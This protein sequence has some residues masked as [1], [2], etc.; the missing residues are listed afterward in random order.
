MTTRKVIEA[1][2]HQGVDESIVYT[3]DFTPWTVTPI[4]PRLSIWERVSGSWVERT[5]VLA[6]TSAAV[7]AGAMVTL[8]PIAGVDEGHNYLP[9][10]TCTAGA[11][12]LSCEFQI[13]GEK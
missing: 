3:V 8:P 10:V 2:Q 4:D 9:I 11:S 1:I 13:I 6:S 5:A 12:I 7:A